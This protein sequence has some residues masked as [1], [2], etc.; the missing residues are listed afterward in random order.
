M[1]ESYNINDVEHLKALNYSN[2]KDLKSSLEKIILN[3]DYYSD[4]ISKTDEKRADNNR[5]KE[6]KA[7]EKDENNHIIKVYKKA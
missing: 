1:L 5:R 3:K 2:K 7:N 4:E 6:G